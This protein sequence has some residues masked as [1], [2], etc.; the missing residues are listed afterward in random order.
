MI[1][2]V[3]VKTFLKEVWRGRFFS[4][5]IDCQSVL[6]Y[7]ISMRITKDPNER[8]KEIIQTSL[9]L[10][11]KKGYFQTTVNEI[12]RNINVAQGTFYHYFKSKDD[13]LDAIIESYINAILNEIEISI[14]DNTLTALQKLEQISYAELRVNQNFNMNLHNIK[15]VD[16]HDRIIRQLTM[17]IVPIMARIIQEGAA[18]GVFNVTYPLEYTEVFIVAAHTLFDPGIFDWD[19]SELQKRVDILIELMESVFGV[20]KGDFSFYKKLMSAGR[21]MKAG[22]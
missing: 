12:V 22:K 9:K 14:N 16:I 3:M 1:P 4:I 7:T 10:F 19:K 6:C 17:K 11:L 18:A 15:G 13:I 20:Q 5:L 8:R 2:E 21:E